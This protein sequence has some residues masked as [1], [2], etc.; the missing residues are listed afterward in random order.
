MKKGRTGFRV[1]ATAPPEADRVTAA[2]FRHSTTAGIR[3]QI[4]ERVTLARREVEVTSADGTAVR[5][6]VLEGPD[7]PESQAGIRRCCSSLPVA[8]GSR[9]MRWQGTCTTGLSGL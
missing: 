5:V 2:L 9:P 3:R 7:G 8:L 4:A 1:E 6:K